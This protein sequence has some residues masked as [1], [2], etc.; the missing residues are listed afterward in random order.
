MS[1]DARF[2]VIKATS[3]TFLVRNFS[4]LLVFCLCP[5]ECNHSTGNFFFR[6]NHSWKNIL[7]LFP[8]I[9]HQEKPQKLFIWY[10]EIKIVFFFLLRWNV[11]LYELRLIWQCTLIQIGIPVWNH[12]LLSFFFI[13]TQTYECEKHFLLQ[14]TFLRFFSA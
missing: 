7:H 12:S 4:F 1:F 6:T 8:F 2:L 5:F 14:E 11:W 10:F 3:R 13:K 9:S